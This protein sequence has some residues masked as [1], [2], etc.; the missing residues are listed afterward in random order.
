LKIA[1]LIDFKKFLVK[2]EP[3]PSIGPDDVLIRVKACGVCTSE[4][5]SWNGKNKNVVFPLY[6]GHEPS[7]IVEAVGKNVKE[8]KVGDHVT[9]LTEKG[10]YAE[11]LK[12]PKDHVVKIPEGIPFEAAL[13][14][15]LAC[16]INGVKRSNIQLGDVVVVIGCGFMGSLIIQG[17][18]L[19][20]PSKIIAV[21]LKDDRLRLAE[22]LGADETINPDEEDV[23]KTVRKLTNGKGAD[24]VIEATGHQKPLDMAGEILKIKGRLVIFGYHV[25]E[26]R[27]INMSLWNWKGLDVINAHERAP[28]IYM[29]GMRI[30]IALLDKGLI[31]M[32]PLITHLY[33]LERINEAF[34]TANMQPRG[35][36]K[37]VI[38]P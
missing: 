34:H 30:G 26:P 5:Y 23:V 22:K 19:R 2:D 11:Y 31:K 1:C 35:F 33:P 24:V 18:V 10:G 13:G 27:L 3:A 12:V 7:G 4:L 38:M 20:G 29:E 36:I 14:E 16:A 6:L 21:D 32:R 25:G 37:A 28:N 15:P 17:V 9:V 8:L